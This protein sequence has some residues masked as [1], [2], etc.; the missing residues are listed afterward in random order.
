M[1]SLRAVYGKTRHTVLSDNG[2]C[3]V[4]RVFCF[5][6]PFRLLSLSVVDIYPYRKCCHV[7]VKLPFKHSKA[8]INRHYVNLAVCFSRNVLGHTE[9]S[10]LLFLGLLSPI[11]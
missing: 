3:C 9:S 4:V 2:V 11:C 5:K 6:Q 7:V 10:Q 8:F 1:R